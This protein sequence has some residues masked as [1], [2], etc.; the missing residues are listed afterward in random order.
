MASS[1]N[2]SIEIR[3]YCK[4]LLHAAKYP[5]ESICGILIGSGGADKTSASSQYTITNAYPVSHT[6]PVGPIFDIAGDFVSNQAIVVVLAIAYCA[7]YS[8]SR[9]P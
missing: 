4:L 6:P 3:A 2:C 7:L 9:G 8:R 5:S 1:S